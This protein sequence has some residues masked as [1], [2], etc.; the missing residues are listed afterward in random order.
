M[1]IGALVLPTKEL[2]TKAKAIK[3]AY[4]MQASALTEAITE[5]FISP[6]TNYRAKHVA[7][8]Q[9]TYKER[10]GAMTTALQKYFPKD[11]GFDWNEPQGG[12]FLWFTAP[13]GWDLTAKL[14]AAIEGGVAYVPGEMFFAELGHVKN[15]ARLNFASTP[16]ANAD[17]AIRRLAKAFS[18]N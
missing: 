5:R 6:E 4:N 11:K 13:E 16:A 8:L 17:E 15:T 7:N 14:D 18:D 3:A 9:K 12:M 10:L 1:R 2:L